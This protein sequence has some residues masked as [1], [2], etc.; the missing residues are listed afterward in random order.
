M[1]THVE[2]RRRLSAWPLI[3]NSIF[4]STFG[5][6]MAMLIDS[7]GRAILALVLEQGPVVFH[8]RVELA[9]D[10]PVTLAGGA[11]AALVAGGL[12]LAVYPGS[13]RHDASRLAV[14]WLILHCLRQGFVPLA[15]AAVDAD[16]DVA[17]ALATFEL[18]S[19]I[20]TVV[21]AAGAIGLLLVSLAAAPAFLA[22]STTR[23]EIST[24]TRRVAYVA[25]IGLL[26]GLVS[27]LLA[28]VGFFVLNSD[29]GLVTTLPFFGAFTIA[30]LLA[31]PGTRTVQADQSATTQKFSW[32]LLLAVAVIFSLFYYALARG[33]PIP[34]DP[35]G[36]FAT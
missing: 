15:L 24:P 34:P 36:F 10:N 28:A 13:T 18:P 32:G 19:G 16:S 21:G 20:N 8:D 31:A 22:F 17:V 30:T 6:F 3:V 11:I 7:L 25:R 26:P 29:S 9:G 33:I 12:F 27:G 23:R 2:E 1:S 4:A 35:D 14:L 5:I